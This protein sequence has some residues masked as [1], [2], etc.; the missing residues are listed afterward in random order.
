MGGIVQGQVSPLGHY[1]LEARG[2]H[3]GASGGCMVQTQVGPE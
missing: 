3:D 2:P 1:N